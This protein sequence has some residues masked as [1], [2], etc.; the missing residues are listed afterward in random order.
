[1]LPSLFFVTYLFFMRPII[2][3]AA[4]ELIL[5]KKQRKFEEGVAE[6]TRYDNN[7]RRGIF[8]L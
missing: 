3:P 1:M 8:K 7:R 2:Y 5:N 4:E 6:D